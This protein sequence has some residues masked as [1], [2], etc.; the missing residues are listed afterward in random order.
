MEFVAITSSFFVHGLNLTW[1]KGQD[2]C[3]LELV[4]YKLS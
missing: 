2:L 1:K 4:V 3:D